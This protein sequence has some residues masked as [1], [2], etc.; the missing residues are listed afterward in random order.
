MDQV[1]EPKADRFRR[2]PVKTDSNVFTGLVINQGELWLSSSTG[3][4]HILPG[5][6]L[7][8]FNREDGVCCL[9]LF[10]AMP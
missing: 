6:K 2:I 1:Y 4:V 5:G 10:R 9:D 3:L 8:V 7:H